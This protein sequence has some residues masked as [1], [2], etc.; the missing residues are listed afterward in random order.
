M[1]DFDWGGML[2]GTINRGLNAGIDVA[3][4]RETA[5]VASWIPNNGQ[6]TVG[7]APAEGYGA[8]GGLSQIMPLLLLAA[9]V[10]VAVK[11]LK[12]A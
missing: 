9:G 12:K 1:G 2:A 6:P 5:Q 7:L 10:F 8:F 3:V 11:L 4:A